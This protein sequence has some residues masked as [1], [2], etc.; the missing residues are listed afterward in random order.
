MNEKVKNI[1]EW[2]ECIVIAIVL[3]LLIRYY[4][5]TPTVVQ[6]DSMYPTLKQ[7]ERLVLNRIPRTRKQL[8]KRGYINRYS[9]EGTLPIIGRQG[10]W[11]GNINL[12]C[13]KFY[14]TEHAVV[15]TP[16]IDLNPIWYYYSLKSL[17]L[18]R[19]QSGAAQPGL[20]VYKIKNIMIPFP[21]KDK[22]DDFAS[23]V[24]QIDK[25]KFSFLIPSKMVIV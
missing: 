11:A 22:Q 2:I 18:T 21:Q 10:A 3:A 14:A 7:G 15:V 5:G 24:G 25:L 4:V 20:S 12:A 6:M 23:F 13:G 1:L 19:F 16:L 9:H 8:P 17:D